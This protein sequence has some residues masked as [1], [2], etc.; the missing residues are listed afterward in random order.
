MVTLSPLSLALPPRPVHQC[1]IGWGVW[2]TAR[3]WGASPCSFT[4]GSR[5]G[6][7]RKPP[8]SAL[9]PLLLVMRLPSRCWSPHSQAHGLRPPI[10]SPPSQFTAGFQRSGEAGAAR[11]DSLALLLSQFLREDL[12][13]HDPTI[14]HSTFHGEDKLI[15]VED[16]WKSWKASEGESGGAP[17]LGRLSGKDGGGLGTR[18]L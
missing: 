7:P 11:P 6:C 4:S 3:I 9:A 15:S 2:G 5:A 1:P 14:K 16:L 17:R 10:P 8:H 18:C 13:Y 12:N